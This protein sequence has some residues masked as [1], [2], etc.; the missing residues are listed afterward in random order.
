MISDS[1]LSKGQDSDTKTKEVQRK[2]ALAF[3]ATQK[4]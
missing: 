2:T 4:E 1:G 3:F